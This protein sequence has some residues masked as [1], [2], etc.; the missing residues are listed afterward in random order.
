MQILYS[1]EVTARPPDCHQTAEEFKIKLPV[2]LAVEFTLLQKEFQTHPSEELN[3]RLVDH[4]VHKTVLARVCEY[5]ESTPKFFYPKK[6][7][8][9]GE[10]RFDFVFTFVDPARRA[11]CHLLVMARG[12]FD[13]G[14]IPVEVSED[15]P[16]Y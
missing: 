10:P 6:T 2:T 5:F 4:I 14:R 13:T 8:A 11:R 3:A 16:A 15:L 1:T 12:A 9:S 7:F